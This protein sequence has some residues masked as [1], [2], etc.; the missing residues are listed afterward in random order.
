MTYRILV[1]ED[2]ADI[3]ELIAKQLTE[4]G[5][6][7]DTA[8]DGQAGLE[9]WQE[10]IYDVITVDLRIPILDGSELVRIIKERQ[11]LTQ[12][13]ILS[14]LGEEADLINAV[15]HHVYAYLKKVI[16]LDVFLDTVQRA[17]SER[18][19]LLLTLEQLAEKMPEQELL[20]CGYQQYSAHQIYDEVRKGSEVGKQFQSELRKN[21][22]EFQLPYKSIDEILGIESVV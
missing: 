1:V 15:N 8:E 12:V 18:D 2:D 14:G 6:Q 20:L 4:S 9:L 22:L 21:L 13:I 3:C 7:V 19:Q 11:P 16:D 5:Y 10:H 17:I